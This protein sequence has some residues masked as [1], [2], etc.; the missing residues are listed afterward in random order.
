MSKVVLFL[1][2]FAYRLYLSGLPF[3][4]Q[5]ICAFVRVVFSCKIGLGAQIGK[6]TVLGYGGLGVVIHH[7]VVIGENCNIGTGVTLGGTNKIEQVPMIGN[8][9]QISTGAKIIGPVTIGSNSVVGANAVVLTDIPDNSVAVGIPA[10]I[11]KSNINV[12]EYK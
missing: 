6:G 3:L 10:K 1:Y 9:T 11:I 7:R 8:N 5:L 4:P 12:D 2:H